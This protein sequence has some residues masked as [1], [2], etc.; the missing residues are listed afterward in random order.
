MDHQAPL[1]SPKT[2]ILPCPSNMK[3]KQGCFLAEPRLPSKAFYK[4]SEKSLS[5]IN[6]ESLS[7]ISHQPSQPSPAP[8][9][10]QGFERKRT[11]SAGGY[12]LLVLYSSLEKEFA[13]L[14][15]CHLKFCLTS[16][17]E[18]EEGKRSLVL[19]KKQRWVLQFQTYAY[20]NICLYKDC[21]GKI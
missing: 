15:I 8:A 17:G 7:P 9:R 20:I 12:S 19:C 5:P 21:H 10:I 3:S 1:S 13:Y 6:K 4:H 11:G 16:G 14:H 18:G 2:R